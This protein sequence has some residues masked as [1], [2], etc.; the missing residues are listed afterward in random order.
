MAP[1]GEDVRRSHF[2][3]EQL[4]NAPLYPQQLEYRPPQMGVQPKKV[5]KSGAMR[6]SSAQGIDHSFTLVNKKVTKPKKTNASCSYPRLRT[7]GM[8]Q[9]KMNDY[10][11]IYS[12]KN[13]TLKSNVSSDKRGGQGGVRLHSKISQ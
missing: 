5:P 1:V 3:E 10:K 4:N 12:Q 11:S 7:W 13:Q 2:S 8:S 6:S 9:K